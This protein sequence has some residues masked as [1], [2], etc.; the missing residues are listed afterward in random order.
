M[1]ICSTLRTLTFSL[2]AIAIAI[3]ASAQSSRLATFDNADGKTNF[4]L[5]ILPDQKAIKVTG[6]KIVVLMDTSA[7]QAGVYRD[8]SMT[9]LIGVLNSLKS[10]DQVQVVAVDLEA[11]PMMDGFAA[12]KSKPVEKSLAKLRARAPLGATD[13]HKAIASAADYLKATPATGRRVI[14]IGDG[15]SKAELLE[16][17]E[18]RQ[19]MDE[20][21][22]EHISV[23][24]LAIGPQRN[25]ELLAAVANHTGGN[26]I[27]DTSALSSQQAGVKL[28]NSARATVYWP[29]SV[30]LP[31]QVSES[32]PWAFPPLRADRDSILVGSF[33]ADEARD[34]M[35]LE[36]TAMVEGKPVSLTWDIATEPSN[37]DFSY[38]PRLVELAQADDGVS[39]P[40]AGSAAMREVRRVLLAGSHSLSELGR[41]E[42]AA[43]NAKGAEALANAALANDPHNPAA[44]IVRDAA[45]KQQD[46]APVKLMQLE[47]PSDDDIPLPPL[48]FG[49]DEIVEGDSGEFGGTIVDE[50]VVPAQVVEPIVEGEMILGEPMIESGGMILGEPVAI[51]SFPADNGIVVG[52]FGDVPREF[53]QENGRLLD[54]VEQRRRARE[55]LLQVEVRNGI[56]AGTGMFGANPDAAVN[57]MKL[58][59][60]TVRRAADVGADIRAQLTDQLESAIRSGM[61]KSYEKSR[62]DQQ[63]AENEAR[64]RDRLR[65]AERM[66]RNQVRLEQILDRFNSLVDE[67]RFGEAEEVAFE[68]EKLAPQAP[69]IK[70]AIYRS[71]YAHRVR[72]NERV[73]DLAERRTWETLAL[74]E[75]AKIPFPDE[76]PLV[77]PPADRWEELTIRR[78]K[79]A[80]IDLAKPGG[81]EE[82]IFA[83]LDKTT[84]LD[85]DETTL[86]DAVDII[87]EQ[88]NGINIVID[89][90]ALDLAGVS[91]SDETVSQVIEGITLRSALRLV[92][93]TLDLTYVVKDEVLLITTIEEA[94]QQLI[95]KVYPVGDLVLPITSNIGGAFGG[96]GIGGALN[97]GGGGGLGGGGGGFGGGG[98]GFGGGGGGGFGGGGFGGGGRGGGGFFA[99]PE[100][101]LDLGSKPR[102]IPAAKLTPAMPRTAAKVAKV[103][104]VSKGN[105]IKLN[106]KHADW[107]SYFANQA[108]LPGAEQVSQADIRATV[109][110]HMNSK[111]F[112]DSIAII[113]AALANNFHQM[114]MYES[115]GLAMQAAGR[116]DAEIE[117]AVMSA[118][119]LASSMDELFYTATYM[120]RLGLEERALALLEQVAKAN[121]TR[122]EPFAHALKI[123]KRVDDKDAIRWATLGVMN[124]SWP[125]D[126]KAIEIETL[127]TA[128][129]TLAEMIRDG[130]TVEAKK[131]RNEMNEALVR[132]CVI[133]VSWTGDGDVDILVQEPSGAVCSHQNPRTRS[134]G[135]ILGDASS[136]TVE[137]SSQPITETYVCPKGFSGEYKL[138]VKPVFGQVA[139]GK[140][141]VSIMIHA[142]TE[143]QQI[144][145]RSV[146]L[147]EDS[148]M[149]VFNLEDGRRNA[150]LAEHIVQDSLDSQVALSRSV[151]S[152]TIDSGDTSSVRD[153]AFDRAL[154]ARGLLGR[155]AVG[156]RPVITALP[157]GTQMTASA[158]ISA[159]RRYVRVSPSPTFSGVTRIETFNFVS[160][161]GGAQGGGGGGGLGGG[162]GGLGGGGGGLGGG[163][164]GGGGGQF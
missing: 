15:F 21:K 33:K 37:E 11:V 112:D 90:G 147:D 162:G 143:G 77:Y 26:V 61:R 161:E 4:A 163:G 109:A 96:G 150:E 29:Q 10:Q 87:K 80:S 60:E 93:K 126:Q 71:R 91:A 9:A 127:R 46:K 7:S 152:Q 114:W 75:E 142:G 145:N 42:L 105:V 159:D 70:A 84:E 38:L 64:A 95:T 40:T 101:E 56:S 132:D 22:K 74:V 82:K 18:F 148:S 124:Y 79:Y 24:S 155:G 36:M 135:V 99:V 149:V 131:Y 130:K 69:A 103:A 119:D 102:T 133:N 27:V 41:R 78:A 120:S 31:T 63:V 88:H 20:L 67:G 89:A 141:D 51:E 160:G 30:T 85:F 106:A 39:L 146:E 8:D 157:E 16:T 140:V 121:P 50:N 100:E 65:I 5:S 139:A 97:G 13:M 156:F 158:V 55:Q 113:N 25:I 92:L 1:S 86:E 72:Q 34:G 107:Q 117:R 76:P 138:L 57:Q 23:S 118:V 136:E 98:G 45:R 58:L 134:G 164:F 137:K 17:D 123:A 3:P 14:Y 49:A 12:A 6:R 35:Q 59:L 53:E 32:Y 28:A 52:S 122:P 81:A 125:L 48:E 129:A 73:Q 110:S 83:E 111:R 104:K 154:I 115:M 66:E 153:L 151:L 54:R 47:L 94:E 62:R 68:A 108:K 19:L 44:D 128:K 116:P 144:I 43:G 2:V